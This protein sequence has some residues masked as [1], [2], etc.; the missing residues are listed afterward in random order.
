MKRK[1]VINGTAYVSVQD[2]FPKSMR[3]VTGALKMLFESST[4]EIE[5][6]NQRR[7]ETDAYYFTDKL[8]LDLSEVRLKN[9]DPT[10]I[11]ADCDFV[12]KVFE[13][14]NSS[15]LMSETLEALKSGTEDGVKRAVDITRTLGFSENEAIKH[16]GGFAVLLLLVAVAAL[17][18]G[19]DSCGN[20]A[21]GQAGGAESMK[22]KA[23][24][25]EP[26]Q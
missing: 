17:A 26:E 5:E 23:G 21:H 20:T 15:G 14:P 13:N 16:G 18:A 4:N 9:L 25:D 8:L 6:G 24:P 7:I 22:P 2:A 19:C 1:T 3:E 10:V 11:M 12:K